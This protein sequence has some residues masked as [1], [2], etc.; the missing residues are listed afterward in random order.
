[1]ELYET[2]K[3]R[4]DTVRIIQLDRVFSSWQKNQSLSKTANWLNE[5]S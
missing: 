5:N 4:A 2:V 3:H 1:M